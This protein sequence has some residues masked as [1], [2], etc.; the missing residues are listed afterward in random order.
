[1]SEYQTML[2]EHN[3]TQSMSQKGTCL[4]NSVMENF[5]GI[6]KTEM[7]YNRED[8]F[9]NLVHLASEIES[10][11]YFYNNFRIKIGLNGLSPVQFKKQLI[12][13]YLF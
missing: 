10:Y 4:D 13:F 12:L 3:V 9:K 11:I 5:F 2:K 8:T 1:M 6:L 7:F